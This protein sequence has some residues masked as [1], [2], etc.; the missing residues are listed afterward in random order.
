[1]P[2]VESLYISDASILEGPFGIPPLLTIVAGS[3]LLV[4]TLLGR[5]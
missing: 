3:K 5:S 4:S 1:V 2:G